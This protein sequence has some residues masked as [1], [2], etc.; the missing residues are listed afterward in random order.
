MLDEIIMAEIGQL[1]DSNGLSYIW[2]NQN[3]TRL[4][5]NLILNRIKDTYYQQWYSKI[6]NSPRLQT[7]A[8]FKHTV[9][10]ENF[11]RLLIE[12]KI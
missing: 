5:M 6:N 10:Y 7:Y 11:N 4:Q 1:Q 8:L 12:R 3:R 9:E 2:V